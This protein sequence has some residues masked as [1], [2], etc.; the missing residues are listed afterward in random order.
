MSFSAKKWA[1][2]GCY[3]QPFSGTG[4]EFSPLG[5]KP[6]IPTPVL[7]E[8]GY[9][10]RRPHWNYPNVYSP[11]WRLYYDLSPGHKVVFSDR[12][13]ALGPDRIILIPDHHLF[14]TVGT[15]QRPKLWLAFSYER[16]PMQGQAIPIELIPQ[17]SELEV[18]Q[19]LIRLLSRKREENRTRVFHCSTALLELTLSRPEIEWMESQPQEL[20]KAVAHIEEHFAEPIYTADLSRMVGLKERTFARAFHSWH[21]VTPTQFVLQVRIREAANRLCHT[22]MG[23]EE[24]ALATGFPNRDYFTRIFTRQTRQSPAHFRRKN[25]PKTI[26]QIN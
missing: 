16:R 14:H 26:S 20:K 19:E 6:E 8:S 1:K 17:R 11:F 5:V 21:G 13:V 18:I 4:V 12:E 3:E 22:Q 10:P 7:H 23:L 9:S 24:I 25:L 15:E 2:L